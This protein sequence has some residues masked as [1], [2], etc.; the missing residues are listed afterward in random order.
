MWPTLKPY[1]LGASSFLHS[2]SYGDLLKPFKLGG[3]AFYTALR[4]LWPTLKPYRLGA[5]SFSHSTSYGDLLKPFKLCGCCFLY[6]TSCF[7][8]YFEALHAWGLLLFY[9]ALRT[10]TFHFE[11]FQAWGVAFLSV[12]RTVP[13]P[14]SLLWLG[15]FFLFTQ[16]FVLRLSLWSSASFVFKWLYTNNLIHSPDTDRRN[17]KSKT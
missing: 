9:T 7:V 6:S 3:V 12:L 5:S 2:T 1:R 11:V 13:S 16:H 17:A 10:V 8:A 14:W 4:A 15:R